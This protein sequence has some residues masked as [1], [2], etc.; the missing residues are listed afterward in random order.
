M[1]G[2]RVGGIWRPGDVEAALG[3]GH[4]TGKVAEGARTGRLCSFSRMPTLTPPRAFVNRWIGE[5]FQELKKT[6]KKDTFPPIFMFQTVPVCTCGG[7]WVHNYI[8]MSYNV[9]V[10]MCV[11]E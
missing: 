1:V 6:T 7:A 10:C 3:G 9:C 2:S 11:C 8:H 5:R 4:S